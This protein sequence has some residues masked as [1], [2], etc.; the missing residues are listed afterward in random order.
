M[1][2]FAP[3]HL[4]AGQLEEADRLTGA[5]DPAGQF[6]AFFALP[7]PAG[8]RDELGGYLAHCSSVAPQFRWVTPA[9]LHLTLRFLGWVPPEIA[10][11]VTEAVV[12]QPPA[13]FEI[14]LGEL[15]SFG[16]G[17]AARVVWIG[18][19]S[20]AHEARGLAALLEAECVRAGLDPEPRVLEPHLT[21]A[22]ARLR[23]G[24][25]LPDLPEPPRLE[26]WTADELVLFRSHL[27]RAGAFYEPVERVRLGG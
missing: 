21:L 14:E 5:T 23:S 11:R 12:A 13:R 15:G 9:N 6:R 27:K 19:R 16:R 25:A 4:G 7:L 18:L 22:R 1:A 2:R 10:A 3:Q 26:S 8:H 20:G 17:R 24:S